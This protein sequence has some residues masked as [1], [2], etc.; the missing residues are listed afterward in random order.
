[1]TSTSPELLRS[2]AER[3]RHVDIPVAAHRP[4]PKG[5]SGQAKEDKKAKEDKDA[6]Q[7]KQN[8]FDLQFAHSCELL[9]F[10]ARRILNCVQEAEEAVKNCRLTAS[11]NPPG[12]SN[13]GAFKSWLVRILI[14][15]ATLLLRRKHSDST[16]SSDAK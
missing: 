10:I 9:H 14:D 11:R 8:I 5:K 3:V 12:F 16:A 7:D 15:E 2:T 4:E 6:Q 13:E 1:M